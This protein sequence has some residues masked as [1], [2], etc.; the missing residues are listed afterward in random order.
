MNAT[1]PSLPDAPPPESKNGENT[2]SK[3]PKKPPEETRKKTNPF[4]NT[5]KA[6]EAFTWTEIWIFWG[7]LTIFLGMIFF[8]QRPMYEFAILFVTTYVAYS[9]F[10]DKKKFSLP[11]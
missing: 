8:F 5:E 9:V 4:A 3:E 2:E 11:V 10:K 7:F 6:F 1:I